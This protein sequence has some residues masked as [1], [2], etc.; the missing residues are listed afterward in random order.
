MASTSSRSLPVNETFL[1][2][3]EWPGEKGPLLCLPSFAGHKG[4]FQRLAERLSPEYRLIALDL[5]GRGDSGKPQQGYGFAYHARDILALLQQLDIERF[6]IIGHSFGATVGTY[7]ASIRPDRVSAIVL[8]EGGADPTEAVLEAIRPSLAHL[9]SR[10]PSMRDYL[11]AMRKL[12]WYRAGWG[13]ALEAYLRQD[14]QRQAD[15]TVSPKADANALRHDLDLHFLYSMCLHFPALQC[16]AL[17]VRAG[18]GLLGGDRG[19][20]FSEAETD[21]IVRWIPKGRRLDMPGVNHF[22]LLLHDDPPVS[23]P[24]RRF[25]QQALAR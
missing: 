25:L 20:I 7:L 8:L 19:H 21:A 1:S 3:R 18:D 5:R 11:E 22:T 4:S 9:E 2:Y 23:E 17:F 6:A 24:V 13:D 16:P 14:V 12:P 10:F 15:G